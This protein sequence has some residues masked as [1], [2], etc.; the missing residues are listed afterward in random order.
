MQSSAHGVQVNRNAPIAL[1]LLNKHCGK[2]LWLQPTTINQHDY[3]KNVFE[4]YR[5]NRMSLCACTT[6]SSLSCKTDMKP[7]CSHLENLSEEIFLQSGISP[8]GFP[9]KEEQK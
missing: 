5:S 8:I 4:I 6:A 9:G 2:Q 7:L 1:A 3:V